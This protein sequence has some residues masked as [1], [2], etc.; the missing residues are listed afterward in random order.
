MLA[1]L[2]NVRRERRTNCRRGEGS[3]RRRQQCVLCVYWQQEKSQELY[4]HRGGIS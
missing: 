2:Y 4:Y 3:I 1:V